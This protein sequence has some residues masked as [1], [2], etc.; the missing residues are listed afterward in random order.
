MGT[1]TYLPTA[2]AKASKE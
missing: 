1:V 2:F